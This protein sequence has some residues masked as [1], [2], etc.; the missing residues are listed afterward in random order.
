MRSSSPD[1]TATIS[2]DTNQF[3]QVATAINSIVSGECSEEE[4]VPGT[5]VFESGSTPL[6]ST[7]SL[8]LKGKL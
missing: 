6:G 7:I 2:E 5:Q 8:S 4:H 3:N 1:R